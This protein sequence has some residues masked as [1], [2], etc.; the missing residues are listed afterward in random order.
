MDK[1]GELFGF[2]FSLNSFP[3]TCAKKTKTKRGIYSQFAQIISLFSPVAPSI[4]T[5]TSKPKKMSS[6]GSRPFTVAIEGNI[7]SGKSTM[8]KTFNQHAEVQVLPEP[9]SKW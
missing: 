6:L 2:H 5:V 7:G 1:S 9:V 4:T 3:E 8:L